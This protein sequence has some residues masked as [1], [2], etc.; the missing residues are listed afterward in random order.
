MTY[1][2]FDFVGRNEIGIGRQSWIV[3]YYEKDEFTNSRWDK[4]DIVKVG[5]PA[6]GLVSKHSGSAVYDAK[7]L[8]ISDDKSELEKMMSD[9]IESSKPNKANKSNEMMADLGRGKRLKKRKYPSDADEVIKKLK[10]EISTLKEDKR[11]LRAE[12]KNLRKS[13]RLITNLPE[14]LTGISSTLEKIK[15]LHCPTSAADEA[16]TKAQKEIDTPSDKVSQVV[17]RCNTTEPAKLV[18]DLLTGLFDE[19][20]I[21]THTISGA[22][23][24]ANGGAQKEGMD[25][26]MVNEIIGK[27]NPSVQA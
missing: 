20:Y 1:V 10:E 22:V 27:Q 23:I 21:A 26:V 14:L 12:N 2:L 8:W 7:V 9:I 13:M 19:R 18:N 25:P 24:K 3:S 17:K 15:C 11:Q 4:K 5:W 6:K 16:A